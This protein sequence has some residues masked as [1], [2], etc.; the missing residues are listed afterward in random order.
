MI[1]KF[2]A[3][4]TD[5]H[6]NAKFWN[7]KLKESRKGV[8]THWDGSASDLSGIAWLQNPDMKA[9]YHIVVADDGSWGVLAPLHTRVWHAGKC[10][11]SS[12]APKY[13]D[14]NSAFY[15]IC[16]L[17]GGREDVTQRQVLTTAWL[18]GRLFHREGWSMNDSHRIVTHSTEAWP[19]G[20]K[21]DPEGKDPLNPILSADD[22]RSLLP[23]FDGAGE[24]PL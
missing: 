2:N 9:G 4:R 13:K 12:S 18:A 24:E 8:M 5:L 15:G 20:R 21:I 17:N 23:L 3:T 14:A 22:V 6:P 1:L 11:P 16:I 10:R 7:D 19:R